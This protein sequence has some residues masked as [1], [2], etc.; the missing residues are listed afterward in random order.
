MARYL[1]ALVLGAAGSAGAS[2][3]ELDLSS[4]GSYTLSLGGALWLRSGPTF[5]TSDGVTHSTAD[6]SLTLLTDPSSPSLT[7]GG[8]DALG[9]FN[10][11]ELSWSLSASSIPSSA[12][13]AAAE[14]APVVVTAFQIYGSGDTVVFEQ[15]FPSGLNGTSTDASDPSAARSHVSSGFPTFLSAE[16]NDG[17]G[18]D[19][20]TSMPAKGFVSWGGRFLEGSKAGAWKDGGLASGEYSGPFALFD[21][22]AADAR[23]GGA[24]VVSSFSNF[25]VSSHEVVSSPA[26]GVQLGL[27][28][29]VQ[30]VPAG[31][32]LRTIACARGGADGAGG[33]TAAVKA[34]GDATLKAHGTGPRANDPTLR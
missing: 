14:A 2:S 6:G 26:K 11:T 19:G 15:R 21:G 31:F 20:A 28:G 33:V 22:D 13:A 29:S 12:A 32:A 5:F 9:E 1:A 30:A 8:A 34:W 3:L 23:A 10:R 25:A 18:G 17:D 16:D 4:D 7:V 24:L 27:L